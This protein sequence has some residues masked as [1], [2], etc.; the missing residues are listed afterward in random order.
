MKVGPIGNGRLFLPSQIRCWHRHM[1][2]HAGVRLFGGFDVE[3]LWAHREGAWRPGAGPL[4]YFHIQVSPHEAAL[5]SDDGHVS[6]ASY[7]H[8]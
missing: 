7:P 6:T 3:S 4:H 8:P 2:A 5:H 1:I